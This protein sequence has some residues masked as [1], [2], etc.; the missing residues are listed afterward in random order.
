M[1]ATPAID[2]YFR[3]VSIA[4]GYISMP[5]P[6]MDGRQMDMTKAV[7]GSTPAELSANLTAL[8][9]AELLED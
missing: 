3:V 2:H 8:L 6:A 5:L 7:Y 1:M 4:N 9:T